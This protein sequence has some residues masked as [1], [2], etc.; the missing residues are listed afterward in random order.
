MK[1]DW[2]K[3]KILTQTVETTANSGKTIEP[4]V[5]ECYHTSNVG[6]TKWKQPVAAVTTWNEVVT[7]VVTPEHLKSQAVSTVSG[8]TTQN[9]NICRKIDSIE[10]NRGRRD[11]EIRYAIEERTAILEFDAVL[12]RE[13][14]EAKAFI[15]MLQTDEQKKT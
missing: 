12:S 7:N 2:S 8:V 10:K 3:F 11:V 4:C 6:G 9:K 14:A 1:I 15:I 13:D 5:I